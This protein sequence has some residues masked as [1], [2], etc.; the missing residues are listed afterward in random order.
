[1]FRE[2]DRHPRDS[3][4]LCIKGVEDFTLFQEACTHDVQGVIYDYPLTEE[5]LTSAYNYAVKI[6]KANP[7]HSKFSYLESRFQ[8]E[9][10]EG[11]A[12]SFPTDTDLEVRIKKEDRDRLL[13]EGVDANLQKL[14]LH[15]GDC[16]AAATKK[17]GSIFTM[18]RVNSPHP[19][20]FHHHSDTIV[21]T[22]RGDTSIIRN[23]A[24]EEYQ[25]KSGQMFLMGDEIWHRAPPPRSRKLNRTD[26]RVM[27]MAYSLK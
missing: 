15:L 19:Q 4:V 12:N 17:T 7:F 13:E 1:M 25:G 21:M 11:A 24:D 18:I 20:S 8:M 10:I 3:R 26:P 5:D 23:D 27:I 6:R 2:Q 22:L 9:A 16:F 14:M